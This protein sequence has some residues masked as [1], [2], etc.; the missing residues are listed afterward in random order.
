MDETHTRGIR[1]HARMLREQREQRERSTMSD[2][3]EE[4]L[5][6]A[7]CAYVRSGSGS[8]TLPRTHASPARWAA[9]LKA[10]DA[11]G[12]RSPL[13]ASGK[14]RAKAAQK[15]S[16]PWSSGLVIAAAL[17]DPQTAAN[18][19]TITDA[20]RIA[21]ASQDDCD[22]AQIAYPDGRVVRVD[23]GAHLPGEREGARTFVLVIDPDGGIRDS[24]EEH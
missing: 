1:A 4:R 7:P 22:R 20:V 6:Q 18:A 13:V 16:A 8:G 21:R 3:H 5:T 2:H 10:T 15:A 11:P 17:S 19:E 9:S 12:S 14:A 24:Y 23:T